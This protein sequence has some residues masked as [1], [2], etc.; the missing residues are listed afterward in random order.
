MSNVATL[1]LLFGFCY[2][3]LASRELPRELCS[4][5]SFKKPLMGIYFVVC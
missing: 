5:L 1:R 3:L 4:V 2:A